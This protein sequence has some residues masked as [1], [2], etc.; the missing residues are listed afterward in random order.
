MSNFE[1]RAAIIAEQ[2]MEGLD[3]ND[4]AHTDIE[5]MA[6]QMVIAHPGLTNSEIARDLALCFG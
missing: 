2:A 6:L 4:F 1:T 3:E 5:A